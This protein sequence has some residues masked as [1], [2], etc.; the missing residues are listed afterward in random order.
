L[1]SNSEF[2]NLEKSIKL[3]IPV[4]LYKFEEPNK[5]K[6]EE[7]APKIKYFIPDSVENSEFL[8]KLAR[9]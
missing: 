1:Y 3:V 2:K 7:N 4:K 8:L 9:M 6:A 5:S